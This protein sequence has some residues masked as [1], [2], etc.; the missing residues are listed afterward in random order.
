MHELRGSAG[1]LF[2]YPIWSETGRKVVINGGVVRVLTGSD[3]GAAFC[4]PRC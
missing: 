2:P 4:R 1:M 3:G